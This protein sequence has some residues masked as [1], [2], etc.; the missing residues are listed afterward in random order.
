MN[1]SPNKKRPRHTPRLRPAPAG[2]VSIP[3]LK[4]SQ[5]AE[6]LHLPPV[7]ESSIALHEAGHL[8][9]ALV[10]GIPLREKAASIVPGPEGRGHVG[11]AWKLQDGTA[12]AGTENPEILERYAVMFLAGG[13]AD[14][15]RIG[16]SLED[17]M[18]GGLSESD[19]EQVTLILGE[20]LPPNL[21][22]W[23][24]PYELT[25]NLRRVLLAR[26]RS[27]V[28][29]HWSAV[30]RLSAALLKKKELSL[31]EAKRIMS[32]NRVAAARRRAA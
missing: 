7:P 22:D 15:V 25:K 27:L 21:P 12:H 23:E 11:I 9:A 10:L 17:V 6:M 30:R 1:T 2:T 13:A 19:R 29:T 20:L 4:S 26:A 31:N 8:A 16:R 14:E 3:F 18:L 5:L 24:S 28:A 32:G